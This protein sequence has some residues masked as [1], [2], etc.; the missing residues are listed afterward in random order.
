VWSELVEAVSSGRD[1]VDDAE[2][3]A[4]EATQPLCYILSFDASNN[5]CSSVI[6]SL[7]SLLPHL[8]VIYFFSNICLSFPVFSEITFAKSAAS[9]IKHEK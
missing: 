9:V 3:I 1:V 7:I 4:A 6:K 5:F 8:T 2:R